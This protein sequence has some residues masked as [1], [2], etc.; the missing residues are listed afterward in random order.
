MNLNIN[1]IEEGEINGA[2]TILDELLDVDIDMTSE[3][4]VWKCVTPGFDQDSGY[5]MKVKGEKHSSSKVK[6][7]AAIDVERVQNIKAFVDMVVTESR[8]SQ[9]VDKLREAGKPLLRT[10]LGDYLKWIQNDVLKEEMD[11]IIANG[12]EVKE[13]GGPISNAARQWWFN[14][15]INF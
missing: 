1:I 11:T 4:V 7:I 2:S 3:G 9:S 15:E 12:F 6:T 13:L 5:W 14:N 8:C 10:S